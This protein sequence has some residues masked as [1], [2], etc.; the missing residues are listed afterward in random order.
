M[1]TER[2][3]E[4][5]KPIPLPYS[6]AAAGSVSAR[7]VFAATCSILIAIFSLPCFLIGFVQV[8]EAGFR[9][10]NRDST[11]GAGFIFVGVFCVWMAIRW[12]REG[13]GRA[14]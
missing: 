3:P 1:P 12:G 8:A 13:F 11:R 14:K 5:V 4:S 9:Y 7:R 10:W 6:T 2:D